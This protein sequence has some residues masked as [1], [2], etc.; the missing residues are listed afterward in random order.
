MAAYALAVQRKVVTVLFC[1]LVGSTSLGERTDPEVLRELMGRYH[2]ELRAILERHGGQVEKFVGDAAMAVFGIPQVHEDDALRAVRASIEMREAVRSLGLEVRIG[3]NTGEVVAGTGETLVTGDAVN[4][5]A[6]LEQEAA[7]NDILLGE[8]THLLVREAVRAEAIE[9]L[10]LKGKTEPVSAWRLLDVLSDVPAFTRRLD[11]PFVGR[12]QELATLERALAAATELRAPQ[13]ATVVGPAGI[14]KSRLA[15]ELIQRSQASVLVGRCLSYGEGI[16]YWPLA[17]IVAQVGDVGALVQDELVTARVQAATGV[18]TATAEDIAW[19]FRQLFETLA[20]RGPLIVVMDD[21]HW[22]EATLLDLIEYL[23]TVAQDAPLL[24][25]CMAR[26]ELFDTRPAW[27]APRANATLLTLEPLASTD[28][29]SLVA[30]LGG[31]TGETKARIVDVAEGNPLFVEQLV[32]MQAESG[33]GGLEVPPTIQALLAARIDMLEPEERAVI[34]RAAVEGRSFHRGAVTDLLPAEQRANVGSHL[35][36]LVRKELIRPD[37][38]IVAGDDGFRFGHI[39]IRDAA[40]DSVPKRLRAEL[41]ERYADWLAT[42]LDGQAPD[43][44]LG[45]HLE[46]AYRYGAELGT[47]DAALGARAAATLAAAGE[48]AFTRD[49]MRAAV[50]LLGR[51]LALPDVPNRAE[52]RLR[53]ASALLDVGQTVDAEVTA[54]DAAREAQQAGDRGGEL[55]AQLFRAQITAWTKRDPTLLPLAREAVEFFTDAGDDAGLMDAWRVIALEALE[56]GRRAE[57]AHAFEQAI[58]HARRS[59]HIDERELLGWLEYAQL[60]G[61]MPVADLLGWIEK[62]SR[63]PEELEPIMFASRALVAAMNGH[64]EEARELLARGEEL[65]GELV[66]AWVA[67]YMEFAWHVETIAGDHAAAE[68]HARRGW[69]LYKDLEQELGVCI[70]AGFV[71]QALC[72]QAR[73]DEAASWTDVAEKHS[74]GQAEGFGINWR[75]A[76]AKVLAHRGELERAENLAREAVAFHERTDLLLF[77]GE[78]LLDLAAVLELAGKTDEAAAAITR[79]IERYEQKGVAPLAERARALLATRQPPA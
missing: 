41:H 15:R 68:R 50:N 22:A 25:L 55:R 77:Q 20:G 16:T 46:Q 76:R 63:P 7:S 48:R 44:I 74:Q 31:L 19:G 6:R 67:P 8:R 49:D 52:L 35:L 39:L 54:M 28:T 40:Y 51:T 65:A 62:N 29:E 1:D 32:A 36:T 70:L 53:L 10:R 24:L 30:A 43:E 12:S 33:D 72:G 3:I 13:L 69:Q 27:A 64:I 78:A 4:V 58:A 9:P 23:A 18:G 14:G 66:P 61:P 71:A 47:T 59:G 5:A 11:S 79:A 45:Y 37:R 75:E 42:S 17:E 60:H 26:P 56:R 38:T 2:A 21:I 34:E 57:A 73:Y